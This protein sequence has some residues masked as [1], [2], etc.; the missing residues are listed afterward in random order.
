VEEEWRETGREGGKEG[1]REGRRKGEGGR[2]GGREGGRGGER[3]C[4]YMRVLVYACGRLAVSFKAHVS[5]T[6]ATN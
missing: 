3:E 1:E 4:V 6:L 2:G 5:N